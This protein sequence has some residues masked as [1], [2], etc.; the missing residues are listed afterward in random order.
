MAITNEIKEAL[1]TIVLYS[2]EIKE[3]LKEQDK[4][5]YELQD[6]DGQLDQIYMHVGKCLE[7]MDG[8]FF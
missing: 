1:E 2:D 3:M 5:D 4:N 6:Y 8:G 7:Q